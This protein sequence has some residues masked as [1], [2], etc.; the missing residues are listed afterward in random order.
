MTA[1]ASV[2]AARK[3]GALCFEWRGPE[4]GVIAVPRKSIIFFLDAMPWPVVK[5]GSDEEAGVD[6]YRRAD[7]ENGPRGASLVRSLAVVPSLT[8]SDVWFK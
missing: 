5:V 2:T 6:F 3:D 7:K 8:P 1:T 4:N